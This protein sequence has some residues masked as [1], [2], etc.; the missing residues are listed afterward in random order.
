MLYACLCSAGTDGYLTWNLG[1]GR[2]VAAGAR[3][4]D[5]RQQVK[6]LGKT[7]GNAASYAVRANDSAP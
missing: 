1:N 7:G 4:G 6:P 5:V 2:S 3:F